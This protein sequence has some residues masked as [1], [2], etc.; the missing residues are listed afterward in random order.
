MEAH[1]DP[2][3]RGDE[4]RRDEMT[5]IKRLHSTGELEA[6][7]RIWHE[8]YALLHMH[9]QVN[10]LSLGQIVNGTG[11]DSPSRGTLHVGF[12]VSQVG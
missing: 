6:R 2:A 7:R 8:F 1:E 5:D 11:V 10:A 4:T 12:F 3:S 9:R